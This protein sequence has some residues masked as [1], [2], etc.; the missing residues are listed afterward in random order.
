MR[1]ADSWFEFDCQSNEDQEEQMLRLENQSA[2]FA[3][4]IPH[5][6]LF[7]SLFLFE[8]VEEREHKNVCYNN[9]VQESREK[10]MFVD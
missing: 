6:H 10:G 1:I 2:L 3:K 9:R 8:L 5:T 7:F 4:E